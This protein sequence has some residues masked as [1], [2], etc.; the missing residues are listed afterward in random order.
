M[1]KKIC[2]TVCAVFCAALAVVPCAFADDSSADSSASSEESSLL[3]D[4]AEFIE[5][6]THDSILPINAAAIAP[7]IDHNQMSYHESVK[8]YTVNGRLK[9]FK[10]TFITSRNDSMLAPPTTCAGTAH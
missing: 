3:G 9:P 4:A 7:T 5:I 6:I 8:P 2:I 1:W 10:M